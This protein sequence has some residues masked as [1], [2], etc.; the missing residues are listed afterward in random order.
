MLIYKELKF[1]GNRE[2]LKALIETINANLP[3]GWERCEGKTD[4]SIAKFVYML[5]IFGKAGLKFHL[6]QKNEFEVYLQN[7]VP[8]DALDNTRPGRKIEDY[9]ERLDLFVSQ[10]VEP[11]LPIDGINFVT[12]GG[13]GSLAKIVGEEASKLLESFSC[14]SNRSTGNSHPC[15]R[16]RWLDFLFFLHNNGLSDDLAPNVLCRWLEQDGLSSDSAGRLAD[17][18]EHDLDF[19]RFYDRHR[20][21][22]PLF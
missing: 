8:E 21:G 3:D 12:S 9:N 16:E 20:G 22:L 18:Y 13:E 10:I 6:W 4:S 7:I 19:L 14:N 1:C 15:D 5:K 11:I 2:S 17:E